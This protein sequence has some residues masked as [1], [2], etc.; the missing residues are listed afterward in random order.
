MESSHRGLRR[1]A[2]RS[3]SRSETQGQLSRCGGV[4]RSHLGLLLSEA[5]GTGTYIQR[6]RS[7]LD[8]DEI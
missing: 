6:M 5:C 8:A 7:S 4:I 3:V 1:L 2:F